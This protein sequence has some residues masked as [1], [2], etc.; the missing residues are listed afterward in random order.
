MKAFVELG[1][2]ISYTK[3]SSH[4]EFKTLLKYYL[5]GLV[6]ISLVYFVIKLDRKR[7]KRCL[8]VV[9]IK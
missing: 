7:R 5:K 3:S 6:F 8:K 9:P 2:D 1:H 4:T